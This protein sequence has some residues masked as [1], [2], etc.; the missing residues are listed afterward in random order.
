MDRKKAK[1]PKHLSE[2]EAHQLLARAAELD[3][4]LGTSVTTEQLSAAALEAGIS[5]EALAQATTDFAAGK[6]GSPARGAAVR[7][8]IVAGSRV[9][10]AAVLVWWL[11]VDATRP[12]AQGLALALAMYGAYKALGWMLRH[13]SQGLKA[14]SSIE[15]PLEKS[16][17]AADDHTSLSVRLLS[18]PGTCQGAA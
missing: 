12:F 5:P 10:I 17:G 2:A 4:R 13:L 16:H 9:T 14:A 8:G 1:L 15:S 3:A 7:L 6:L 11:I 18:A